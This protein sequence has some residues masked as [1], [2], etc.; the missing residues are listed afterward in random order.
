MRHARELIFLSFF[1]AV[2]GMLM[3][4]EGTDDNPKLN[5]HLGFPISAPLNP[6]ARFAG[7]GAGLTYGAGYNFNRR[8]GVFGEFMWDW[9]NPG[10][11]AL[12]PIQLALNR[13]DISGHSHLYAFTANYRYELRG[14]TLGM[15]FIA[16]G[17]W[18]LR[19]SSLTKVVLTGNTTT[20][21]DTEAWLWWGYTCT[22]GQGTA[23]HTIAHGSSS[24]L[25]GNAGIGFTA[26]VGDAPYRMYV[27]SRY[28]Y[29][30]T[31]NINTQLVVVTVGIRY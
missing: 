30:P 12:T 18:Y 9:L 6:M 3:A 5:T 10:S 28:H 17:G 29:A 21:C 4:Q 14:K 24:A 20:T 23:N 31:R 15:Y 8:N 2:T 19:E 16:G 27:E 7:P 11:G 25:G 22:T 13:N 26:R 1:L